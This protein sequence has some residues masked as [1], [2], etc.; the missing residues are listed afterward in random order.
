MRLSGTLREPA[1]MDRDMVATSWNRLII[2]S[3]KSLN[4]TASR[5][6]KDWI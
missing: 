3:I 6:K 5:E 1:M 4:C 2:G